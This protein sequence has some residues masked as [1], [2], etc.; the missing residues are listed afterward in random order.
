MKIITRR[1]FLRW[2]LGVPFLTFFPL[3]VRLS[4]AEAS[5][6][7]KTS[8]GR[9][10]GQFF[11]GEVLF[12]EI[13]VWLFKRAALGRLTFK[14]GGEKGLYVA[15]LQAETLGVLGWVSRRRV[16]TYRATMEEVEGGGRLRAL[17]FEEDVKIGSK[18]RRNSHT[19][20]HQKRRWI[21]G[22]Q[23]KDGT[24]T[25]TEEEIPPGMVYDDFITA[26]YNFRYGV[27]GAVGR[28]RNYLVPT[29]PRKGA[30]HYE[31]K[32][33]AKE[34][35]VSRR[36]QLKQKDGKEFFVKLY[37]D[38]EITHSKE[39]LIEGWLSKDLYPTEGTIRNV[40]FFG[41][42]KGILIKNTKG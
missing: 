3:P 37:L 18:V 5:S 15:T 12:Y 36:S 1:V 2:L 22:R 30:S 19:F 32:V 16:D 11:K 34:E 40:V 10:I 8:G 29:F 14:E 9:S 23:R 26:S 20:D 41:D 6:P 7:L 25:W 13:G 21:K 39:G 33:A 38:P 27:Y 31:V 24:M 17:S 4:H 42:V 28:G 35:E